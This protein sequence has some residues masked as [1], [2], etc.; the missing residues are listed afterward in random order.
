MRGKKGG[1]RPARGRQED[2]RFEKSRTKKE[3][4]P[5]AR[6]KAATAPDY[7]FNKFRHFAKKTERT[8]KPTDDIRLNKFIANAGVCSRREAD[9]LIESG[10]IAVNGK[11]VTEVGTKVKPT[12]DVTY[13]GKRLSREKLVYVLL[14]KPKDAVTTR[15][16]PE[17][18]RTVMD[19]V[20]KAGRERLFPVGRLDR[21]TTGL[22]LL[23]NDGAL[24]D[25]LAHPSHGVEKLYEVELKEPIS[26][27]NFNKL[28]SGIE[29]DD[30]PVK[31]D[32]VA[33]TDP[34]GLRLGV[35]IHEGRNRI[36]RRTFEKLGYEINKLD[37]VLYAGLTKKNLPRGHW[38]FLTE[39]EVIRLKYMMK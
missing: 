33:L 39:K 34:T 21:N 12:D 24:A 26:E 25:R 6:K 9:A 2:K 31:I 30:G 4:D 37:R 27:E 22:L 16:D 13:K 28:Q 36:I 35:K 18:R 23:T 14:N 17:G 20:E 10:V 11:K 7:N 15:K 32:E 19:L 38:R 3:R 1:R 29:L 5:A 8:E